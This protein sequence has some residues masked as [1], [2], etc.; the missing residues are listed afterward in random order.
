MY[1]EW[2]YAKHTVYYDALPHYFLEFD[3]LDTR[4]GDFLSTP[5]RRAL[6]EPLPI[7]SVPVLHEGTLRTHAEL[8]AFVGPSRFKTSTWRDRLA[9]EVRALELDV[10]R[11]LAETDASSEMEGL[12]I[13][14]EDEDRVIERLKWVRHGFLTS[15]ADSGTHWLAR[16]IVPNRLAGDTSLEALF[17]PAQ[18]GDGR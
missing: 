5:R 1:G 15:V 4:T 6:L 11:A 16:P 2:V 3:V 13:K 12:Y 8:V 7:A 18:R 10:A 14:V 9:E 17:L